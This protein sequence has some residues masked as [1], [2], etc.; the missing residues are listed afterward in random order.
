MATQLATF[1]EVQDILP[2][3]TATQYK[4]PIL[5]QWHLVTIVKWAL[6]TFREGNDGLQVGPLK[7][8]TQ[9]TRAANFVGSREYRILI[10][11]LF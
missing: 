5:S 8:N 9:K 1:T 11:M 10:S 3:K 2:R 7:K 6:P 4:Y